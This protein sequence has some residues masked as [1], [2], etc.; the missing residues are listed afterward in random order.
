MVKAENYFLGPDLFF[1]DKTRPLTKNFSF[2]LGLLTFVKTL[3]LLHFNS[4]FLHLLPFPG[5]ERP[6][7]QFSIFN[8]IGSSEF[9]C[10]F[11][12]CDRR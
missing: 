4:S 7:S 3:M 1:S 6:K 5:T 2:F 10:P 9:H 11:N 8:P 12:E